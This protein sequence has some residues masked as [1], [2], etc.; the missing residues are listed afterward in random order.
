MEKKALHALLKLENRYLLF[1]FYGQITRATSRR[2]ETGI[3]CQ[4]LKMHCSVS[5]VYI[6]KIVEDVS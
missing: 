3:V 4:E 1:V 5:T 6:E 2:K